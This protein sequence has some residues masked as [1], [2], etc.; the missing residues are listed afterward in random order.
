MKAQK[1][2]LVPL[3]GIL[4]LLWA[5]SVSAAFAADIN[6]TVQGPGG[7]TD[8]TEDLVM[9]TPND[10]NIS[11][12]I[13]GA[14][15]EDAFIFFV[16]GQQWNGITIADQNI[17]IKG[18]GN[19]IDGNVGYADSSGNLDLYLTIPGSH[20]S[21]TFDLN[22]HDLNGDN[23]RFSESIQIRPAWTNTEFQIQTD[24]NSLAGRCRI[25]N[26]ASVA[27]LKLS[28]DANNSVE[29]TQNVDVSG[30][31][32]FDA[33]INL[34]NTTAEVN[35]SVLTTLAN[36]QAT[37]TWPNLAAAGLP[38]S[39]AGNFELTYNTGDSGN[40]NQECPQAQCLLFSVTNGTA[41]LNV[42]NF[43]TYSI[44]ERDGSGSFI[45]GLPT[46]EDVANVLG[47]TTFGFPNTAFVAIGVLSILAG[48]MF[49]KN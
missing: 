25:P 29:F 2:F 19:I 9:C 36:R 33:S 1:K 15:A 49:F 7:E 44:S 22:G 26:Y 14:T 4:V 21:G 46:P 6:G 10:A 38:N 35:T 16:N 27:N 12:S 30:D 23:E 17:H 40:A 24:G 11:I 41:T 18:F 8:T 32:D 20:A 39:G 47:G 28:N 3:I 37:I 13:T 34:T 31:L 43:S 42:E 48:F 45:P 5:T